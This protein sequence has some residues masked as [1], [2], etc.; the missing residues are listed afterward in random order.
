MTIFIRII[1]PY[2]LFC[3]YAMALYSV[4]SRNISLLE[5]NGAQF[6][7]TVYYP[8]LTN[9]EKA[10][11]ITNAGAFPTII[12]IHGLMVDRTS[13][14]LLAGGFVQNGYVFFVPDLP[15]G[16]LPAKSECT[17]LV[18]RLVQAIVGRSFQGDVAILNNICD[19][20]QLVAMGHSWGGGLAMELGRTNPNF[21]VVLALAP[22]QISDISVLNSSQT[23]III[24]TG[25]MDAI[26]PNS[27][28]RAMYENLT[29]PKVLLTLKDGSHNGFLDHPSNL[30]E[31]LVSGKRLDN[32][33][34]INLTVQNSIA[35][36]RRYL[37][38]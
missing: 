36:I 34:Q 32:I 24:L 3:S 23:P 8:A 1:L 2:L 29:T 28:V 37:S 35:Y 9:G 33:T 22:A 12:F 15:G 38:Y 20:N 6:Q 10:T 27:I 16:A 21:K 5:T 30:E 25:S 4:G 7:M 14:S 17:A 31:T 18:D 26:V 19:A 11:P 13:F